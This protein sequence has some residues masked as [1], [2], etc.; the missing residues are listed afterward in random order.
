MK[1]QSKQGNPIWGF[2]CSVRLT[3]TLLILL[4]LASIVGTLIPQKE[5][6]VEF[7]GSLSP[8]TAKLLFSLGLFDMYHTLW[9]R[10]LVAFLALNL[11]SCSVNRL[12][13]T[14][15]LFKASPRPDREK[16]FKDLP[17]DRSFLASGAQNEVF[18]ALEERLGKRW[19]RIRKK[20]TQGRY[21][22]YGEKGRFSLFGFYLVHLS[23]LFILA[24][25]IVGSLSGFEGFVNIVEGEQVDSIALRNRMGR[26]ELGFEVRCDDFE[27]KTYP[28][29]M[30]SQY[31]SRLTFL[32][33][34]VP[35]YKADALVNHPVQYRGITFYQSSY[36]TV[37]GD[38]ARL[39][40]ERTGSPKE[41]TILEVKVGEAVPL[42]GKGGNFKVIRT[43]ADFRGMLG[44]A[45]QIAVYP[46]E[47]KDGELRIWLFK[48]RRLLQERFPPQM[49][50]AKAL[51][52][53]AF[54]PYTFHLEALESKHYTGL[55]VNR[56]PGVPLVWTGCFLMVAGFI[57]TFFTSHR[58]FWV[59]AV[60][61]QGGVRVDV[62]GTSSKNPVGL[63]RELDHL[64]ASLRDKFQARERKNAS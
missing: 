1:N 16:P 7:A 60:A 18:G 42:P 54:P 20:E 62:S 2:L 48:N 59:R 24:G 23:V 8:E 58:R 26:M 21:Y 43:E 27:H 33:N 38:R 13:G 22:F 46:A 55:Q 57:V 30:P 3:I 44:P 39:R 50:K 9:F 47:E 6:A 17:P 5:G 56:D 34:G 36:G 32:E 41:T 19:G 53:S 52:P 12:P 29:G 25:S 35:V 49:L 40:I 11:I 15:R 28:N 64:V 61:V 31:R 45:V 10:F 4:A 51:N 14:W 63:E 37:A